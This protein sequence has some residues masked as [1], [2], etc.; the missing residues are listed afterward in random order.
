MSKKKK[1]KVVRLDDGRVIKQVGTGRNSIK[2]TDEYP[3]NL[4]YTKFKNH[5][6]L[7]VFAEKGTKCVCCHTEGVK[8]FNRIVK[9]KN[10]TYSEHIDLYTEDLILMTVDHKLPKYLKGSE[11]I[12]NKQTM[13]SV[14][15]GKKGHKY[16]PI[17]GRFSWFYRLEY[18]VNRNPEVKNK[19]EKVKNCFGF[20]SAYSDKML[21]L[22]ENAYSISDMVSYSQEPDYVAIKVNKSRS[23]K[24]KRRKRAR[25]KNAI[26]VD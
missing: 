12:R 5:K 13:C 22:F 6:R 11:D 4:L 10:G 7:K 8:L 24:K 21:S 18:L 25:N 1:S 26:F 2:F 3:I 14:C 16:I 19:I 9:Y 23:A 17:L 20:V 15:N